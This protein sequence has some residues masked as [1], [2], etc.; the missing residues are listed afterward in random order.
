MDKG[1]SQ[2][3]TNVNSYIF[4]TR[5]WQ[6]ECRRHSLWE[7]SENSSY[8]GLHK[9]LWVLAESQPKEVWCLL[10]STVVGSRKDK[11]SGWF[12]LVWVSD[13]SSLQWVS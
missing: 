8:I 1:Y 10:Q 9:M 4:N 2:H 7:Y 6:N 13:V 3:N 11:A 5:Q 12:F